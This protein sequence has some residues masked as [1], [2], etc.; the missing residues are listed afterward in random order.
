MIYTAHTANALAE[1]SFSKPAEELPCLRIKTGQSNCV[2]TFYPSLYQLTIVRD[3]VEEKI[4]LGYSGGRLLE[5]LLRTPGDVVDRDELMRH[6]WSD[7]VV[8]Q[9]SLN[10]QIYTLRQIL[11]DEKD[12]LIIQTLPRRGYLIN[13]TSIEEIHVAPSSSSTSVE[14]TDEQ[15]T[16]TESTL[17]RTLAITS[18]HLTS[19]AFPLV[20]DLS[21]AASRPALNKAVVIAASM[22]ALAMF[23]AMT[24]VTH[25]SD[26]SASSFTVSVA[27]NDEQIESLT[28]LS[29]QLEMR[30]KTQVNSP[31]HWVLADQG[32][33]VS[34]TCIHHAGGAQQMNFTRDQLSHISS[35][36]LAPCLS[37][38]Q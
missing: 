32:E 6:A 10:Q 30:F 21:P 34:L 27:G 28:P 23:L 5:R 35:A 3:G 7:R 24:L 13:P 14:T 12:R 17:Q 26:S 22:G 20:T 38:A 36:Q 18:D 16:S 37:S 4:D 25:L 9:G 1:P 29:Q 11:G 19:S 8:G 31:V 33:D 2:A 15:T